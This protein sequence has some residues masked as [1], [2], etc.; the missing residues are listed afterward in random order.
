MLGGTIEVTSK[1]GEGSTFTLDA[2]RPAVAAPAATGT[3]AEELAA[4]DRRRR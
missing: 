4:A 1:P 2:A 3:I